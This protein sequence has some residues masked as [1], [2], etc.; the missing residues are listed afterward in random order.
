MGADEAGACVS[1]F[2][3]QPSVGPTRGVR[4]GPM[5][6]EL[7]APWRLCNST[8]QRIVDRYGE[9]PKATDFSPKERPVVLVWTVTGIVENGGFEYLFGEDLPGDPGYQLAIEAFRTIGCKRATRALRDALRLFPDGKVPA[10]VPRRRA[11]FRAHPDKKRDRLASRF[12]NAEAEIVTHL[13]AYIREER[14]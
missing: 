10:S 12:W 6:P 13:A 5:K 9:N 14:P 11:V 2:A 8:W 4:E 3:A 1:R 7:K